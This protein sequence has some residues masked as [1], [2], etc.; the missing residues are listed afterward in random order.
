LPFT[1]H[2]R[3]LTRY[4]AEVHPKAGKQSTG[5]SGPIR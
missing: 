1:S 4:I 2:R 3:I 5:M